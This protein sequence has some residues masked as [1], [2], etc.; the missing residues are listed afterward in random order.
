MF[1]ISRPRCVEIILIVWTDF[2]TCNQS[3]V[4]A[5]GICYTLQL[6]YC[7]SLR[8]PRPRDQRIRPS[9]SSL[10]SPQH[11]VNSIKTVFVRRENNGRRDLLLALSSL[12]IVQNVISGESDILYIFLANINTAE[13]FDYFYGFRNLMG[14]IAL[15]VILP[16]LKRFG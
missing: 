9:L 8:E 1:L 6:L 5:S 7:L 16:V 11:L 14:A 10:L 15:L 4:T 3:R 2:L 13:F 12:F